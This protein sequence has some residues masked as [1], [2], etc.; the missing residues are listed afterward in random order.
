MPLLGIFNT[1]FYFSFYYF[2]CYFCFFTKTV[3]RIFT[4]GEI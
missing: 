4:F 2:T 1:V 3:F